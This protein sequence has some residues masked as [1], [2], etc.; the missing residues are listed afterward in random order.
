M[1]FDK[2]GDVDGMQY[3][4]ESTY[5]SEFKGTGADFADGKLEIVSKKRLSDAPR[6]VE[7]WVNVPADTSS[8]KRVGV[9]LGNYFNNYYSD[10]SRFNFEIHANG[11]PRVYWRASKSH[12]VNYI[13][14]NVNI[15]VGDWVHVAMV[16]DDTNKIAT[17]YINGEK[18]NEEAVVV[19][20]PTDRTVR[21]LKIG[22][23]YRRNNAHGTPEMTFNGQITDVRVWSTVRTDSEIK[24]N[25]N[26]SLKG[27]ETGLMGNW[28]LDKEANDVYRDRSKNKNHGLVYDEETTNWLAPEF[29]KG[30]YTIAVLPDTQNMVE[31]HPDAFKNYM[32]WIK[33]LANHMNIKLAIQVGDL[34]N[35]PRSIAQWET[36]SEGMSYLDGVIPYVFLPGNHDEILN[37]TQ[38]TRDRTNYNKYFPYSKYSQASTFG[39]S[40]PEGKM[41]NTCHY[42]DI[43]GVEYMVIALEFAP[44][45]DV[46]AWANKTAAENPDKKIIVATHSYMYHTGDQIST[47]HIDYPS[48]YIN[49]GNNGDDMWNEFVSK[50]EN[51]VLVLSGHIGY[52]DLVV[53]EDIGMHGNSVKQVLVDAQFMQ[54]D[55][56]MVMILT[57]KKGSNEVDVNWYSVTKDK[58]YRANNQSSME[59]NVNEDKNSKSRLQIR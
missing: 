16:L 48:A 52:P 56:G 3:G 18:I 35:N 14:K 47:K 11:N 4:F 9:I 36:A 44:N 58:F 7:A 33:D 8:D 53:R 38:M 40:Y 10:I 22:S 27:N 24:A 21:E 12:E 51:I 17:T 30:D 1:I 25:Y 32:T 57:F 6:T 34:V 23:D 20:I 42:F 37:R 19:P 26:V 5:E 46:M 39:G 45:D 49:D 50:H 15:N 2:T 59:L 41:D 29:A 43:N 28:E 55:L 31:Y 54:Y 13:A